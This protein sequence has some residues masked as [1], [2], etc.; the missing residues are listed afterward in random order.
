[1]SQSEVD[2]TQVFQ[3]MRQA[4]DQL[5]QAWQTVARQLSEPLPEP[6]KAEQ[7]EAFE[8]TDGDGGSL[9]V[10]LYEDRDGWL[11]TDSTKSSVVHLSPDAVNRLAQYLDQHRTDTPCS[12]DADMIGAPVA[13]REHRCGCTSDHPGHEYVLNRQS[14]RCRGVSNGMYGAPVQPPDCCGHLKQDHGHH[15]CQ[16]LPC[17]CRCGTS[18]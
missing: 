13:V 16:V 10:V 6:V 18:L 8:Y 15:G 5:S 4:V 3:R 12:P 2:L 14:V 1:M 7:P 11:V 9:V 17:P